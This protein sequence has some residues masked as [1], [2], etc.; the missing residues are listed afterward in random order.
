MDKEKA[1][2]M[3]KPKRKK[4]T[5]KPTND[6]FTML[7]PEVGWQKETWHHIPQEHIESNNRAVKRTTDSDVD[8]ERDTW[9]YMP[10]DKPKKR[11]LHYKEYTIML[12]ERMSFNEYK[13]RFYG[14]HEPGHFFRFGEWLRPGDWINDN[15][16]I[17]EV[18][19]KE[20]GDRGQIV[21][22]SSEILEL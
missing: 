10:K 20:T 9:Y 22:R 15:F 11:K 1:K 2:R 19:Y 12:D 18:D 3:F 6:F 16:M 8:W 21:V 14:T 13:G 5:K 17:T 4:K 7:E